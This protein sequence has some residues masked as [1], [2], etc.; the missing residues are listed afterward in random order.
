MAELVR[1]PPTTS[2]HTPIL[3][4]SS[5][6]KIST[7]PAGASTPPNITPYHIKG[8]PRKHIGG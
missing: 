7:P 1:F 5:L 2:V 8:T 6:P 3:K 4:A